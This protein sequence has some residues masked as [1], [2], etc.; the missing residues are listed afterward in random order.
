[1][2]WGLKM[3]DSEIVV[4]TEEFRMNLNLGNRMIVVLHSNTH[5]PMFHPNI[6][7]LILL[8]IEASPDVSKQQKAADKGDVTLL[9]YS[10]LK[11]SKT[12]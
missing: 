10:S 2:G 9:I 5:N 12:N 8:A 4:K 1:M 11:L 3:S 7:Y 6:H